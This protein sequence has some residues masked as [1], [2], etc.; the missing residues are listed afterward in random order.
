MSFTSSSCPAKGGTNGTPATLFGIWENSIETIVTSMLNSPA[1]AITGYM[2]GGTH[3]KQFVEGE[4]VLQTV[5]GAYATLIGPYIPGTPMITNPI[6]GTANATNTWVG[7]TSEAVL[8]P[9]AA[10]SVT[11]QTVITCN[12]PYCGLPSNFPTQYGEIGLFQAT[13]ARGWPMTACG[14]VVERYGNFPFVW[15]VLAVSESPMTITIR[16]G[17]DAQTGSTTP[18]P[19]LNGTLTGTFPEAILG[20]WPAATSASILLDGR[21]GLGV[22]LAHI[23]DFQHFGRRHTAFWRRRRGRR[24][25]AQRDGGR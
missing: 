10:P 22:G 9:T 25:R 21:Q 23:D 4:K 24:V 3:A 16:S 2:I 5:S 18:C 14:G 7:Q 19:S 11:G 6:T 12:R 13:N 8:T 17:R 20:N 1:A 15:N